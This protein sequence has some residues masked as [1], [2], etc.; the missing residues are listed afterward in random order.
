MLSRIFIKISVF[1]I[2]F[3]QFE[4]Y[5]IV[6]LRSVT[7]ELLLEIFDLLALSRDLALKD[8]EI[9]VN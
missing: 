4:I 9:T 5:E 8:I 6:I 1:L 7:Q 2:K 3:L